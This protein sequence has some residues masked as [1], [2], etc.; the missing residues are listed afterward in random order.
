MS[1]T[2]ERYPK[3]STLSRLHL[4]S[5]FSMPA[6]RKLKLGNLAASSRIKSP[7]F[8]IKCFFDKTVINDLV[9]LLTEKSLFQNTVSMPFGITILCV[10]I[11]FR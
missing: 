9:F 2:E 3:N 6:K 7:P 11:S 10:S 8:K 5:S 4:I 1:S